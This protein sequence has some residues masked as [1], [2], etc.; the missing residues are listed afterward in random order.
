MNLFSRAEAKLPLY[1]LPVEKAS[2]AD[3][4]V[5][6]QIWSCVSLSRSQYK[7]HYGTAIDRFGRY[8]QSAE[9]L[10]TAL[11]LAVEQLQDSLIYR[12][13]RDRDREES[14]RFEQVWKFTCFLQPL[15][16]EAMAI[17]RRWYNKRQQQTAIFID[18]AYYRDHPGPAHPSC[19]KLN[20]PHFLH[21]ISVDW[22]MQDKLRCIDCLYQCIDKSVYEIPE[23]KANRTTEKSSA[24]TPTSIETPLTVVES[25]TKQTT[26]ANSPNHTDNNETGNKQET[27]S[28]PSETPLSPQASTEL[29]SRF[30]A[31]LPADSLKLKDSSSYIESPITIEQFIADGKLV[32]SVGEVQQSLLDHGFVRELIHLGKKKRTSC[33]RV[34]ENAHV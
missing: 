23:Q 5:L 27:P 25:D 21:P 19:I 28:P 3:P 12:L 30:M 14:A 16:S 4:A 7:T 24:I 32:V 18:A 13:P 22:L 26:P 10:N 6:G 2:R 17:D 31:W 34:P 15:L 29:A 8:F 20:F 33:L 9:R 1:F 11:Q